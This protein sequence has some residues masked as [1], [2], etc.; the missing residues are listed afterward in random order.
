[1][2]NSFR[3]FLLSVI[4]LSCNNTADQRNNAKG[5]SVSHKIDQSK[6]DSTEIMNETELSLKYNDSST[7]ENARV[8]QLTLSKSVSV[9]DIRF[10]ALKFKD[11]KSK[12][13]EIMGLPDSIISPKYDCG[14]F[15]EEWQELKFFQ[16]FYGDMNFIVYNSIAE[17]QNILIQED[18][19][20]Y[21]QNVRLNSG[22]SF[23][24]VAEK[25][26]LKI[27]DM[28]YNSNRIEIHPTEQLDEH[29]SLKFRDN[30][31]FQFDRYEPC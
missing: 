4:L 3:L 24:E 22:M 28:N 27:T 14:P 23:E 2:K 12:M 5:D 15:S 21:I 29:Y 1:M 26:E 31:L 11:S 13:E 10:H 30:M 18:E 7:K 19:D 20:F 16:Y 9:S 17:I 25:L 8:K 6:R